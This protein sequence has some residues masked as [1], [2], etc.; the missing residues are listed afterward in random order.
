MKAI[1]AGTVVTG[2]RLGQAAGA[3]M[4]GLRMGQPYVSLRTS[5]P[6]ATGLAAES[7]ETPGQTVIILPLAPGSRYG[8]LRP[9]AS[10]WWTRHVNGTTMLLL[11]IN[12]LVRSPNDPV[13]R[14]Q[15]A[16]A[17]RDLL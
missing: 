12:A 4:Y 9:D 13:A 6:L 1:T 17:T 11:A 2:L 5:A 8:G 15:L 14:A 3:R 10:S 16:A 7:F